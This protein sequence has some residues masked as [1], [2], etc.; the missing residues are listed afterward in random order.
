M[1]RDT[2]SNGAPEREWLAIPPDLGEGGVSG[3]IPV[4][5]AELW[6]LVLEARFVPCRME[7]AGAGRTLLVPEERFSEALDEL[8]LFEEEN[9]DWP[10]LP[11]TPGPRAE[12]TLATLSVLILVATFH[13]LTLLHL[14]L[15][16][17]AP[18]DWLGIGSAGAEQIR[19]GQWW[20]TVTALTLHA[21]LPHLLGNLFIGGVFIV[22]LCRELGSGL[23]WCLLLLSGVFGN[24][25]NAVFQ[26]FYHNSIG[27]STL[28][29]GAV[30]ILGALRL[31][32]R[33]SHWRM[34]WLLPVAG[35]LALLAM[36]GTEGKNTDLGAHLFGFAVGVVLGLGAGYLTGRH[37]H[38]GRCL[39]AM[40]SL[41]AALTPVVAWWA[42]LALGGRG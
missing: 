30:G 4:R 42:A 17:H 16:G 6:A 21:D 31:A 36:L 32:Q 14:P 27:A 39:N 25:A 35:A 20:R 22:L 15:F 37:G 10:P 12:N 8:R 29:F 33:R 34:R 18:I 2:E 11:P 5:R 23:A 9:R 38:P 13:N 19:D 40:L 7:P 41:A 3:P 1:E 24:L 26:P 28:V